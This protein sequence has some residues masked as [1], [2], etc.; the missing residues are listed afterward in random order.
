MKERSEKLEDVLVK[1]LVKASQKL[2]GESVGDPLVTAK[3]QDKLGVSLV[4]LGA[5]ADAVALIE[6]ARDTRL[7]L[8]GPD[9]RDTLTSMDDCAYAYRSVGRLDEALQIWD[10]TLTRRKAT[11]VPNHRDTLQSMNNLG[12]GYDA[13]GQFA[14]AIPL[15]E[16]T[17]KLRKAAPGGADDPDTLGT[18]NNLAACY[19]DAGDF[20][21]ALPLLVE[22]LAS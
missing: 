1:Q 20:D 8:L 5:G 18:M 17:L 12:V 13:A 19:R 2:D 3:L 9:H 15:L 11:L 21:R 4:H 6:K 22:A 10:E 14:K 7:R 16:E